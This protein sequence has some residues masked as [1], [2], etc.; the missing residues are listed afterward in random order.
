MT[1]SG[2]R[3]YDS[4]TTANAGILS[5]T[6]LV[7]SDNVTLSGSTTLASANAGSETITSFAGLMLE[8]SAAG[9][10][11][12]TG[13]SGSITVAQRLITVTADP[14]SKTVGTADPTLTYQVTAGNLV[15]NDAFSGSLTRDP[16]EIVGAYTISQG[17]QTAGPNY[18]VTFV[19]SVLI[20]TATN[21]SLQSGQTV[22]VSSTAGSS[23][24][25]T[26]PTSTGAPQL[27]ATG[28]G[29]DG[30]LTVAQYTA[31][32]VNGF[33]AS[34]SYFDI[35]VGSSDLGTSSSVQASFTNLTPGAT[36]FWFNG[37]NWQAVTDA[38]GQT[39]TADASG[40]ATVTLTT[41]TSPTLA[42]L[43]GTDFFA[44]TFQP[45][46]TVAAG[47]T[48]VIGS[49]VPLTATATLAGGENEAGS[50]TFTLYGPS[51]NKVDSETVSV[52]GNGTYATPRAS[53]PRSP[54]PT[55]GRR[56]TPAPTRSMRTPAPR[57]ALRRSRWPPES[58]W[59]VRRCGS[60][61]ARPP[62][63]T[64]QINSGWAPAIRAA[65]AYRSMPHSTTFTP[66]PRTTSPSRRCISSCTVATTTSQ[67]ANDPDHQR[68]TVACGQRQRQLSS[69][70]SGNNSV[71]LGDGNDNVQRATATTPSRTGQGQRPSSA[72]NGNNTVT[73]GNG[74]D[75]YQ[76]GNGNN[77]V[78]LGNGNDN[79]QAGNGDNTITQPATATTTYRWATAT[80]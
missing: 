40:M 52:S 36:V 24:A 77:T 75:K 16:G 62:M 5:I 2:S 43:T 17:S 70:A 63:T 34:G 58:P 74:N 42:Q 50:I 76:F 30:S 3:T 65:R 35:N 57:T 72:G 80:T 49:G 10:Y 59:S 54:A 37:S 28:S 39:V 79:V 56:P 32:P 9:N 69:S 19:N 13:A 41:N 18:A 71:T 45:T 11:T 60:S 4:T 31:A 29:F 12:L 47:G 27:S 23:T 46:L 25:Q 73:L 22:G 26:T 66:R 21:D 14:Q 8:G 51:G 6:D 68:R 78:T 38:S 44:G 7:G 55:N 53:C 61:A 1:V 15:G 20:I 67:L 64:S 33:S 48:A